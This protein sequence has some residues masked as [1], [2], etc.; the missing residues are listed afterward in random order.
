ML[1]MWEGVSLL[2]YAGRAKFWS[3]G[4]RKQFGT[5]LKKVTKLHFMILM[6]SLYPKK[7]R[8]TG[9]VYTKIFIG[10][11]LKIKFY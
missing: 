2:L 1:E 7:V 4:F 9:P 8:E 10:A 6:F 5:I 3:N 11:Y